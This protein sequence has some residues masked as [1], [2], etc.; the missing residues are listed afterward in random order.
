MI[1]K[2]SKTQLGYTLIELSIGLAITSLVLVGVVAGVQKLMEQVNLNRSVTQIS[3]AA[4]KIKLIIKRDIDTS[5]VTLENVT[6]I[7]NNAFA[8]SNVINPGVAGV[9]VFNALGNSISLGAHPYTGGSQYFRI[10]LGNVSPSA[11]AELAAG[12]EGGATEVWVSNG[13]WWVSVKNDRTGTVFNPTLA[14]KTC[15]EG[16]NYGVMFEFLK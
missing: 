11:C 4:E 15:L 7:T 12:I 13:S 5:Y 2:N 8:T 3:T 9:Q 6:N 10:A 16:K 14:R 1:T